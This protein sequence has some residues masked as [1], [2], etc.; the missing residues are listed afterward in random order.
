MVLFYFLVIGVSAQQFSP[1]IIVDSTSANV[2]MKTGTAIGIDQNGNIGI[3]WVDLLTD[4]Y[5]VYYKQS[6][7][8]GDHFTP[9]TV[10]EDYQIN[11][12]NNKRTLSGVY[13]DQENNPL[14][15]YT[16]ANWPFFYFHRLSKSTDGGYTFSNLP[17]N[18]MGQSRI[19]EFMTFQDSTYFVLFDHPGYKIK[20]FRST[21]L[22]YNFADSIFIERDSGAVDVFSLPI[23]E[24]ENGDILVFWQG[25]YGNGNRIFYVRSLDGGHT[26][27]AKVEIP[28]PYFLPFSIDVT[29]F[30]EMVFLSYA[31]STGD[32]VNVW[33]IKSS[34][35][36]YTYGS[37]KKIY[38]YY[39]SPNFSPGPSI[40]F[41]PAVGLCISWMKP[42]SDSTEIYFTYS[43]DFGNSFD[44]TVVITAGGRLLSVNSLCVSDSGYVYSV[45]TKENPPRVVLNRAQLPIL[46]AI[47]PAN[48][49]LNS[50]FELFQNYPNPFNS[51]TTIK[52]RLEKTADIK[53]DI[54]DITGKH[55]KRILNG[56]RHSG[57]HTV[58]WQG[59][60]DNDQSVSSGIYFCTLKSKGYQSIIKLLL[61]K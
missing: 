25:Q 51:A 3:A 60:N 36:G 8:H 58:V 19:S 61:I 29:S 23:I 50:S 32:S 1:D 38:T 41:N 48:L 16:Y 26:F 54:F 43:T 5:G 27:S 34:D 30:H 18:S 21:N 12:E 37:P 47:E 33:L 17:L 31:T 13:F 24:L 14:V 28:R 22:G 49:S 53:L 7:D 57:R 46:S 4:N 59:D 9:R 2:V 20:L 15:L 40:T 10:I 39:G 55:I 44:S 52:F 45:C 35:Y 42:I 11:P 56:V 6:S